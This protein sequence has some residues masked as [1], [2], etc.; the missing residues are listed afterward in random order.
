MQTITREVTFDGCKVEIVHPKYPELQHILDFLFTDIAGQ[1]DADVVESLVIK[2]NTE[3]N[4]W[5]LHKNNQSLFRGDSL[6]GLGVILMGEVLFHLIRENKTGLAIHAGMVSDDK[7]TTL[8]PGTSGSG[9]SSVTTWLLK[10]GMRYHTDELVTI[11]F[12]TEEVSPFARPLNIKTRGVKAV[13]EIVDLDEIADRTEVSAGVTMI[14]HRLVNPDFRVEKPKITHITFP[15]YIAESEPEVIKL[16][17]A[18]AGLELMRSNV[19]ARNIPNH[20]FKEVIKL[21]KN[22]PAFKIH[23]QHFDDLPG[24]IEAV[25]R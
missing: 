6:P 5:A 8:I 11:D 20:G 15:Q 1:N 4:V 21:V 12:Q 19:I 14:P 3:K 7:S 18:E 23:Y 17:G 2:R 13:S 10:N 16:S 9:K 22:I 25:Y 24:L